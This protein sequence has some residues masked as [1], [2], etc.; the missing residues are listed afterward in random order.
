MSHGFQRRENPPGRSSL[1]SPTEERAKEL[2][3]EL[4]YDG[5]FVDAIHADRTKQQRDNTV[6]WLQLVDEC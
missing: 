4:V 5:I 3:G 1:S 6:T 2:F